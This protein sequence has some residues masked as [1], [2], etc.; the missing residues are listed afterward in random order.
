MKNISKIILLLALLVL[1]TTYSFKTTTSLTQSKNTFFKIEKI[2]VINTNI[3]KESEIINNL[4]GLY[5]KNIITLSSFEVEN[6]LKTIDFINKIEV[7]KRYPDTII[8][9]IYETIPAAI[10]YKDEIKYI[11][12]S[13]AN[14][15]TYK[16]EINFNNLPNIFGPSAENYFIN[17]YDQ[18]KNNGFPIS[19]IKNFYYFKS[20][21]WD[22]QLLNGKTIKFPDNIKI[23]LIKQSIQLLNRKDF[24]DYNII[25]LRIDDKVIVE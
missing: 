15:A 14:L 2:K 4:M 13:K 7:K 9:K 23:S 18:M 8:I 1:L 21:R 20:G 22:I 16:K 19:K 25:D 12:D 17:F 11:L 3:T 6:P 5:G 24:G 10:I